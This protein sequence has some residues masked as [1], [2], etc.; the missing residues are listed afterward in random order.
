M[1]PFKGVG[2]NIL[3]K[4]IKIYGVEQVQESVYRNAYAQLHQLVTIHFLYDETNL[5]HYLENPEKGGLPKV[6]LSEL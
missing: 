6:N 3:N 1:L 5:I 2:C 4:G